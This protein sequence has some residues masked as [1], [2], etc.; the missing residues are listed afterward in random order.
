MRLPGTGACTQSPPVLPMPLPPEIAA[1]LPQDRNIAR[2]ILCQ[3]AFKF[4]PA[5]DALYARIA[6]AAA[7]CRIFILLRPDEPVQSER[8]LSR[9]R[10]ACAKQGVDGDTAALVIRKIGSMTYRL[11]GSA[12]YLKK[13]AKADYEF[14]AFDESLDHVPQMKA[15]PSSRLFSTP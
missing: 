3:H 4:D 8:L 1:A 2:L 13:R 9:L 10:Q 7:P 6:K 5:D 15:R 12:P 11:Y 14:I